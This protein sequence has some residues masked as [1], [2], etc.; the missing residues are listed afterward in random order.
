MKYAHVLVSVFGIIIATGFLINEFEQPVFAGVPA[1]LSAPQ[2]IKDYWA[3]AKPSLVAA[4]KT[5]DQE[6]AKKIIAALKEKIISAEHINNGGGVIIK[7]AVVADAANYVMKPLAPKPKGENCSSASA[8]ELSKTLNAKNICVGPCHCAF[9]ATRF[10]S[11]IGCNNPIQGNANIIPYEYEQHGWVGKKITKENAASLPVGILWMNGHVGVSLGN[12]RMFE[13]GTKDKFT[14]AASAGSCPSIF[15]KS[16]VGSALCNY[17][18]K[19]PG[20]GP[21]TGTNGSPKVGGKNG[22]ESCTDNQGWTESGSSRIK[23]FSMIFYPP[24]TSNEIPS[25]GC[26]TIKNH[27]VMSE[28]TCKTI[29]LSSEIGKYTWDKTKTTKETCGEK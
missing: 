10:L 11:Y 7:N 3:L 14:R 29:G 6:E 8:V 2:G 20:E 4:L 12:G 9:T 26:C 23:A 5:N 27:H 24:A 22:A 15:N 19:V 16:V 18:A 28:L 21:Q 13:S 25:L 1:T 17:C